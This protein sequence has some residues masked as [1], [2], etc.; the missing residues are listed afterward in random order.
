MQFDYYSAS[1]PASVSH[2]EAM[3]K[4][5]HKG[6]LVTEKPVSPYK[7]AFRCSKSDFRVYWGGHNPR[8]YFVSS[9]AGAVLGADFCRAHYPAHRVTRADVALDF[10]QE[11]IFDRMADTCLRIARDRRVA[12]L[13]IGDPD[14]EAKTGRTYYFGSTSSDVRVCLYEKGLKEAATRPEGVSEAWSRCEVRCR[15]R[16]ER[17]SLVASLSPS[18][19]W[20]LSQW[21]KDIAQE[22]AGMGVPFRPDPSHRQNTVDASIQHMLKQYGDTISRYIAKHGRETFDQKITAIVEESR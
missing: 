17:K 18:E 6:S 1:L 10:D 3:I 12:V 5:A 19:C 13:F 7:S 2:C 14:P 16:K 8:P 21:S 4:E 11:G 20:G 15:P 22:V 9:G